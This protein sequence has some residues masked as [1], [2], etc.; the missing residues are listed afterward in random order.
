M[1]SLVHATTG[2]SLVYLFPNPFIYI[3][4][5]L[6]SHYGLDAIP[7]YDLGSNL[8]TYKKRK[9]TTLSFVFF[10]VFFALMGI[11]ILSFFTKNRI[12]LYFGAFL[13]ILPDILDAPFNFFNKKYKFLNTLHL[14][15]GKYHRNSKNILCGILTQVII[16]AIALILIKKI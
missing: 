13:G 12:N 11:I 5:C 16:F 15:H 9:K 7:H 3:P 1:I 2:F 8:K 4:L 6:L 10:D 14:I